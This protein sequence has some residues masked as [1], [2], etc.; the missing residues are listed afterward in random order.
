[1][2]EQKTAILVDSGCDIPKVIREQYD[3][4]I[5][6][7]RVIYPEKDY[8]DGVDIDPMMVYK[9]CGYDFERSVRHVQH[10]PPRGVGRGTARGFSV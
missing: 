4:R 8:R 7:L 1:M 5:L 9:R 2:N 6:P 3:I 10:D